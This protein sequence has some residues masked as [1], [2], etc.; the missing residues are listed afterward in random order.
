MKKKISEVII[1]E[2][3][4]DIIN[5]KQYIT[6]MGIINNVRCRGNYAN[7]EYSRFKISNE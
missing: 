3:R 2:G 7:G 1:V 4:D 5:L 6:V